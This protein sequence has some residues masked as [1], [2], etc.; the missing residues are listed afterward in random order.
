MK[1]YCGLTEEKNWQKAVEGKKVLFW[2][3]KIKWRTATTQFF[4]QTFTS[5]RLHEF[6]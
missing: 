4:I 5:T 3:F 1:L 2:G 6:P